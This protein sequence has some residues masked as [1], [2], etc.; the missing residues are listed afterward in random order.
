[1]IAVEAEEPT[2]PGSAGAV[3]H[4]CLP[5]H[6]AGCRCRC[7]SHP[8]WHQHVVNHM[9][10]RMNE[11]RAAQSGAVSQ[12]RCSGGV[13]AGSEQR[14]AGSGGP[15]ARGTSWAGTQVV[16]PGPAAR[17]SSP[18]RGGSPAPPAR[19][20]SDTWP[21]RMCRPW[22]LAP[23]PAPWGGGGGGGEGSRLLSSGQ[24]RCVVPGSVA[25]YPMLPWHRLRH[26]ASAT[27][28]VH[29]PQRHPACHAG[30]TTAHARPPGTLACASAH[31]E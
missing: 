6:A 25:A 2:F 20:R 23:P 4:A 24:A 5:W 27:P 3:A 8:Y 14:G 26:G 13:T 1:M 19:W 29:H 16:I 18:P 9:V 15:R 31:A 28:Q 10:G 7:C 11:S 21:R 30:G 12:Q 22:C 17:G